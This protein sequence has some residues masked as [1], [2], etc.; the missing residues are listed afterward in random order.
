M[1][2]TFPICERIAGSGVSAEH[3]I[4][5]ECSVWAI[6]LGYVVEFA[7]LDSA[8]VLVVSLDDVSGEETKSNIRR[9]GT[10]HKAFANGRAVD[11]NVIDGA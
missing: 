6:G 11:A 9:P 7:D 2:T 8:L 5:Q 10:V 4:L 3:E 1:Q